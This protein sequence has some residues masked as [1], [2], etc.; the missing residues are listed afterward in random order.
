M[1]LR[2][3]YLNHVIA[4]FSRIGYT[5]TESRNRLFDVMWSHDYPFGELKEM[6]QNLEP[7]QKVR[8]LLDIIASLLKPHWKWPKVDLSLLNGSV[9]IT[10]IT[11]FF[12]N[13][14]W[15]KKKHIST[16]L[17]QTK[18]LL[19][20]F[21]FIKTHWYVYFC[22]SW[23][24]NCKRLNYNWVYMYMLQVKFDFRFILI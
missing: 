23:N 3:G 24:L 22:Y 19:L 4:V 2:T 8:N 9:F 16:L 12:T 14:A 13:Y 17:S 11:V 7:H 6:L 21:F 20:I 1:Q 5:R 15:V 10:V 18:T